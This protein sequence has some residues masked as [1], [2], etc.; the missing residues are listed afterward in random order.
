MLEGISSSA[1]IH[2]ITG[3]AAQLISRAEGKAQEILNTARAEVWLV[4]GFEVHVRLSVMAHAGTID[5]ADRPRHLKA[6][7]ARSYLPPT[8]RRYFYLLF[9]DENPARYLLT[10]K[11]LTALSSI[12]KV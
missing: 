6:R 5:K 9:L 2:A 3:E 8:P 7:C 1:Q 4:L 11:Y 10:Y 12:V